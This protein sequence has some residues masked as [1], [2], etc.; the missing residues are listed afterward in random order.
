ME[1]KALQRLTLFVLYQ[2]EQLIKGPRQLPVLLGTFLN[3][4]ALECINRGLYLTIDILLARVIR[5][6]QVI[7]CL[8]AE[9]L[10][11]CQGL[12]DLRRD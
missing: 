8:L 4:L 9:A 2:V 12:D 3:E 1:F 5:Q 10:V 6:S 11:L 7:K